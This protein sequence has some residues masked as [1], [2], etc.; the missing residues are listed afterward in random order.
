VRTAI[1]S[2]IHSNLEALT[3][4]VDH[5]RAQGA[6]RFV[7]LGDIVGYGADPDPTLQLL[8]SLPGLVAVR[9]NHDVA[10]F[11]DLSVGTP[12][13]I[14]AATEWTRKQLTPAQCEFL[15]QL[16]LLHREGDATYVHASAAEPEGWPYLRME[17][18]IKA[19]MDA[20]NTP[21]TFIGHVHVPNVF[22]RTPQGQ[23]RELSPASG[24][25]VPLSVSLQ[26]VINVGSVGQPRDGNNA[27][28]YAIYDD[29][30]QDVT[31][32]R[33][34]YDFQIA[35]RKIRAAALDPFFAERLA[36]GR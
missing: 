21:L 24:V 11:Q 27:A 26:F 16:P 4:C 22:Y 5:A 2:D 3:R 6:E 36:E 19:C 34:P 25:A 30:R 1:V 20:A 15:Q 8:M 31:F 28:C 13:G 35:A 7:C 33:L 29:V 17:D 10:I 12:P 32:Y 14:R 23:I 18:E 9:G